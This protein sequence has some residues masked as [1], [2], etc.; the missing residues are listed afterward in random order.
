MLTFEEKLTVVNKFPELNRKDISM[1]RV[2]FHYENSAIDKKI[3]VH[4]LHPNGNGFVYAKKIG[5]YKT[6]RNGMINVRDYS[7]KE[8]FEIIQQAI[9][10]LSPEANTEV[11]PDDESWINANEQTLLLTY[12]D[13]LWNVYAGQNLDGSFHSYKQAIQ[14]LDEEGFERAL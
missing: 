11:I 6:D 13:G 10:S 8:L 5:G 2:N 14:F 1:G 7:E 3:V 4:N 12:E 9:Q